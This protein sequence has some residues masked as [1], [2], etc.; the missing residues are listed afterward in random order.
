M[1]TTVRTHQQE[2]VELPKDKPSVYKLLR[3]HN[4]KSLTISLIEE[5]RQTRAGAVARVYCTTRPR[6]AADG[7]MKRRAT[8]VVFLYDGEEL[9]VTRLDGWPV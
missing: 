6:L 4:M 9:T 7:I 3:R 1:T 2:V 8:T 5:P